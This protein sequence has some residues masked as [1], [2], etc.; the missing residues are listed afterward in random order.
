MASEALLFLNE[1]PDIITPGENVH[2]FVIDSLDR[3]IYI[4]CSDTPEAGENLSLF[5]TRGAAERDINT[6][7]RSQIKAIIIHH[8]VESI[9]DDAFTG[10]HDLDLIEFQDP[11]RVVR[12]GARAFKDCDHLERFDFTFIQDIEDEAFANCSSLR[13]V[14]FGCSLDR[15]GDCAFQNCTSLTSAV[16]PTVMHIGDSAFQGCHSIEKLELPDYVEYMSSDMFDHCSDLSKLILSINFHD[17]FFRSHNPFYGCPIDQIEFRYANA[18]APYLG[19]A[20]SDEINQ[21]I[22]RFRESTT[23][24]VSSADI[25]YNRMIHSITESCFQ[26]YPRVSACARSTICSILLQLLSGRNH[27]CSDVIEAEL[28]GNGIVFVVEQ[29][30]SYIYLPPSIKTNNQHGAREVEYIH[31]KTG[32]LGL[33]IDDEF[34]DPIRRR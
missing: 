15:I 24:T 29:V 33:R 9:V 31:N 19:Q 30:M 27:V 14:I 20:F 16:F 7:R 34:Y 6:L 17:D 8:S 10:L 25:A 4:Y 28:E 5:F 21:A 13:G 11:A 2:T 22:E 23:P 26:Y 32:F 1:F 12:I 3:L 18:I